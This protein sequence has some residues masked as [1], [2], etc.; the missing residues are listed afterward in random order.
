MNVELE[1]VFR[2]PPET[3]FHY[4]SHEAALGILNSRT[5]W[6]THI[7]YLNDTQELEHAIG[8]LERLIGPTS[9]QLA[10]SRASV[11]ADTLG[12]G[13]TDLRAT[14]IGVFSLSENPDLL[15]QWRAYCPQ[16]TGYALGIDTTGLIE[17][18]PQKTAQLG[19]CIYDAELQHLLL[20]QLLSRSV[21]AF[22]QELNTPHAKIKTA[23]YQCRTRFARDV[24]RVAAFVK[25][26]SFEE[27]REWRMV[28]RVVSD[29]SDLWAFRPGRVTMVPYLCLKASVGEAPLR[30]NAAVVGPSMA[31]VSALR[32]A[33]LFFTHHGLLRQ[34]V[35]RST[36][37]FRSW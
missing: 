20:E 18:I 7:G 5:I 9:R 34:F 29:T 17:A 33:Q 30:L 15:S 24:A 32:A 23:S 35:T 10:G 6:A 8:Q 25:H 28:S 26:Q 19:A 14:N 21:S 13:L 2:L 37:P 31:P 1:A 12:A 36:V 11:V 4:T 22:F 16:G 3:L 27:E